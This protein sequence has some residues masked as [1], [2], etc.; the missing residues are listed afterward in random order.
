MLKLITVAL[1]VTAGYLAKVLITNVRRQRDL[2]HAL[3]T[4][5]PYLVDE[6]LGR[7]SGAWRETAA[8][9]NELIA[10]LRV[11]EAERK[12]QLHQLEATLG[13]L[14]EG[15]LVVDESNAIILANQALATIFPESPIISG[16]R[17]ETVVR[18]SAF[19]SFLDDVRRGTAAT[20]VELEFVNGAASVWTEATGAV[21]VPWTGGRGQW[22]LCVLHEVTRQKRLEN[23]RKDFVAN[24]SHELRTP[25]S[26]IKGFIE[27]LVDDHAHIPEADRDRFLRTIQRHADRLHVILEDLLTLSRLESRTSGMHLE[28]LE[29]P[30]LLRELVE[31]YRPRAL[32]SGHRID[33]QL[34]GELPIVAADPV[35]LRQVFDNL[36]DNALKYT[37]AQSFITIRAAATA[38]EVE[39]R[40]MDNGPGIPARDLPHIFERFYR[41]DKGRSREKGGTGLGLSIV[42]HIVQLHDGRIWAESPA[43]QGTTIA[44]T[45]AIQPRSV[46]IAAPPTG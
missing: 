5:T 4:R 12:G 31:D 46:P 1:A 17:I 26:V 16:Q 25:L 36:L 45:L 15:V 40:V 19:S 22:V 43:G 38:T 20:R 28:P 21:I 7:F 8:A 37:P 39:L 18:S 42:K 29:L 11:A 27:T 30:R 35:R 23:M 6:G 41:V 24:V 2:R 33:L 34:T 9:A 13:S 14:Q 32:A 10:A 44:F 3:Q